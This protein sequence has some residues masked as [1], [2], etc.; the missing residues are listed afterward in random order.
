MPP[1]LITAALGVVVG[2]CSCLLV[3]HLTDMWK[4]DKAARDLREWN[5]T[6]AKIRLRKNVQAYAAKRRNTGGHDAA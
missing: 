4:A 5:A 6:E 1:T 3:G 2:W